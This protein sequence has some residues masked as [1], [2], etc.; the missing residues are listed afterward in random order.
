VYGVL[1]LRSLFG[2]EQ[3]KQQ[4]A[5]LIVSVQLRFLYRS[6]K[7]FGDESRTVPK[8]IREI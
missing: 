5:H 3:Q 1:S 7:D 4:N 2:F 6:Y 8:I